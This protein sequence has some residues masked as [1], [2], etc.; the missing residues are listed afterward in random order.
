[1]AKSSHAFIE[2]DEQLALVDCQQCGYRY[3]VHQRNMTADRVTEWW[4]CKSCK[5]KPVTKCHYGNDF[6]IPWQGDFDL[7]LMVC[8]DDDGKPYK[9]GPRTCGHA[10]CVR[11]A[12]LVWG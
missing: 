2:L 6:C 8:L 5:A 12:H 10:D 4:L 7:D 11:S 3:E 1:M 9:R